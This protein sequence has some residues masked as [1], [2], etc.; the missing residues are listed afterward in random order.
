M[1]ELLTDPAHTRRD[2]RMI[3]SAIR[4]GFEI[5]EAI[6][7][8]LAKHMSMIVA[9]G[10]NREKTAAA[11]VLLAMAEFNDKPNQ[12]AQTTV[13]VGVQVNGVDA[14]RDRTLAIAERIRAGRV[15]EQHTE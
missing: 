14:K 3:E 6:Y 12:Q 5:P 13:N 8:S 1:T 2:V 4:K 9:K 10:T 15:L 7:Q 11:R